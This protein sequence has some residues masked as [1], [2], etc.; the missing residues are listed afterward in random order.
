MATKLIPDLSATTS[1]LADGDLVVIEK[2][3]GS[4]TKKMTFAQLCQA[5]A[6]KNYVN[7]G[8]TTAA[9]KA[10]DARY[11]KTLTDQV[12]ALNTRWINS[13][14]VTSGSF[15]D[16]TGPGMYVIS[17]SVT[18]AP[19]GSTYWRLLVFVGS[20]NV[21]QVAFAHAYDWV[22]YR[23]Y[24]TNAWTDWVL[25]GVE[26]LPSGLIQSFTPTTG[27]SLSTYG[28]CYYYK[29]GSHVHVHVG[30]NGLT[31]NTDTVIF[32]LPTGYR[33][34]SS[35][36]FKGENNGINSMASMRV[37]ASGSVQVRSEGTYAMV[38]AI[39]DAYS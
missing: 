26:K 36:N 24:V 15:D 25:I 28:N 35:M 31:A 14:S 37:N 22:Y 9:Y 19:Y 34:Y 21:V 3:D 27:S 38:D 5:V 32:T 30:M 4:G 1:P 10:L 13:T 11:G 20:T 17:P 18:N 8:T 12:S 33:P 39:F 7:N 6:T 2:A 29:I 23:R 16:I